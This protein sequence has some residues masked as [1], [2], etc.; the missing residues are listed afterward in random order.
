MGV[1]CIGWKNELGGAVGQEGGIIEEEVARVGLTQDRGRVGFVKHMEAS[2]DTFTGNA[3]EGDGGRGGDDGG[4]GGVGDPA[5]I[6]A[7]GVEG[8]G[9][10]AE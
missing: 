4:C 3:Q 6:L 9:G 7:L 5:G 8:A 1:V 10:G 2:L